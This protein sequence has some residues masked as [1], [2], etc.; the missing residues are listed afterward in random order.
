RVHSDTGHFADGENWPVCLCCPGRNG[1]EKTDPRGGDGKLRYKRDFRRRETRES[2][3]DVI[4]SSMQASRVASS[5]TA[6][7]Q[8]SIS[9]LASGLT[10]CCS[11]SSA[12]P[13]STSFSI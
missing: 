11:S 8:N 5:E 4:L 2:E 9:C 3:R 12:R 10:T 1:G 6:V 13:L 7:L